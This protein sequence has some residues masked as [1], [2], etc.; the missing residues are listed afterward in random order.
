MVNIIGLMAENLMV[1]GLITKW[2]VEEYSLGQ[3]VE[4]TKEN[5]WT[6]KKRA[7]DNSSGQM[8]ES[9]KVAGR[10]VNNMESVPILQ[11]Q[12]KLNKDNGK[13]EKDFIGYKTINESIIKI[14]IRIS[15]FELYEGI[16]ILL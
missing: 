7:K 11:H 2:R 9:M 3:M 4:D 1:P 8:V 5:M 13:K 10:M 6:I 14:N 15:S 16:Y 12:A